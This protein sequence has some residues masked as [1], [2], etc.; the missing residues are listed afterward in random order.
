MEKQV[1]TPSEK[2][3][4]FLLEAEELKKVEEKIRHA[5]EYMRS[6]LAQE[7][8]PSFRD[9]WQ[10]KQFCLELFKEK[11]PAR[12]RTVFWK[13]YTELSD[14]VR[15]LKELFDEESSFAKEQIELAIKAIEKELMDGEVTRPSFEVPK[16]SRAL[17]KNS[18]EYIEMQGDLNRLQPLGKRIN[19]LRKEVLKTPMRIRSKNQFLS[20]LSKLGDLVFPKRR[21]LIDKL[22]IQFI[23]DVDL[24]ISEEF[25]LEKPPY[26]PLKEEIKALQGFAKQIG[27]SS[28]SFT[29]VRG[30]LSEC[31][32]KIRA[33]EEASRQARQEESLEFKANVDQIS[34]LI[35]PLKAQC[36]NEE[37]SLPDA[38][39]KVAE[40][41][42]QMKELPLRH[43][44]V[45]ALKREL[46]AGKKL[47]EE[48]ESKLR[49]A[50]AEAKEEKRLEEARKAEAFLEKL[51]EV[52]SSC[53]T[54]SFQ[55]LEQKWD[56]LVKEGETLDLGEYQQDL[57]TCRLGALADLLKEKEGTSDLESLLEERRETR[58]QVKKALEK[59]RQM[60]GGSGQSL[61]E[62]L[63]NHELVA[64]QR[65]RFERLEQFIEEIEEKVYGLEEE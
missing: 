12:S 10:V 59:C 6:A 22:S 52:L 7:K 20:Q 14:E 45:V 64:E 65:K 48:K 23:Q 26:F 39:K 32:Q 33:K 24:F 19:E 47:L 3:A 41:L 40:I 11:I 35:A 44:D 43:S 30:R 63:F 13:E 38:E 29:Q 15:R 8:T 4:Q 17:Q 2:M 28:S 53:E 51:E 5:L 50:E 49:R 21:E 37:I 18:D 42:K 25:S 36:E 27:L 54:L 56:A 58:Q 60:G 34:A 1:A 62:S 46:F 55:D 9:F 61:E 31:W 16:A 57:A